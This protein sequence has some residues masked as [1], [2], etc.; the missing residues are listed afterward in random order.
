MKIILHSFLAL[1]LL[2]ATAPAVPVAVKPRDI[3]TLDGTTYHHATIMGSTSTVVM[4]SCDEGTVY[5]PIDKVPAEIQKE[6]GYKGPGMKEK[7]EAEKAA[8]LKAQA[9]KAELDKQAKLESTKHEILPGTEKDAWPQLNPD[10]FPPEL[11]SQISAYNTKAQF[12]MIMSKADHTPDSDAA[13]KANTDKMAAL[14]AIYLD[15]KKFMENP[16]AG[17]DADAA[18]K[19]VADLQYKPYPGMPEIALQ[20]IM[21]PP[22]KV[23]TTTSADNVAEKIYHYGAN[24]YTFRNGGFQDPSQVKK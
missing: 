5:I 14:L 16:P 8:L 20:A 6:V 9:E 18:R 1:A 2:A 3:T 17:I 13:I 12:N 19:A 15:Y 21:G 24:K 10:F 7:E 22:D 11:S 23:E 4:I